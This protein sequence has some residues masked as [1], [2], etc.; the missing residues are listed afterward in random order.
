MIFDRVIYG[1]VT[2]LNISTALLIFLGALLISKLLALNLRRSLRDRIAREHLEL[3]V[4][5]FTYAIIVISIILVL[6]LIGVEP[7]GLMVAGG[8]VALA[9]GFASQSIIGNLVSGLF[10]I[11]ERPVKIGDIVE[12]AGITGFVEDIRIISTTLRTFDG[13][14]VRMP[15]ETVFTSRI[16]NFVFHQVRRFDCV[17][18]ISYSDDAQKA[19]K[20]IRETISN[21]PLVLVNPPAQVFVDRLGENSVNIM[22][23]VWVPTGEWFTVRME[24][25]MQIKNALEGAGIEIPLPQRVLWFGD[26]QGTGRGKD[27]GNAGNAGNAGY[28]GN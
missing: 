27:A 12:I 20:I 24:L 19:I 13:L 8:I 6:P 21:H 4:K 1:E 11:M 3:I 17:V 22:V 2:V 9:I 14:Y 18:G 26:N 25:L 15:N 5:L 10:L 23:M 28:A 16:T 7:S